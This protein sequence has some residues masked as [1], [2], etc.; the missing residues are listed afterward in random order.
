MKTASLAFWKTIIVL[1]RTMKIIILY[2]LLPDLFKTLN[3]LTEVYDYIRLEALNVLLLLVVISVAAFV[4]KKVVLALLK[5]LCKK[6][7]LFFAK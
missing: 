3:D 4:I 6:K 2:F 7:N 1:F 5:R